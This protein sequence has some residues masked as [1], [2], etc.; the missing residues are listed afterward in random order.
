MDACRLRFVRPIAEGLGFLRE[1]GRRISVSHSAAEDPEMGLRDL[2]PNGGFGGLRL[3]PLSPDRASPE[4]A[5]AARSPRSRWNTSLQPVGGTEDA[6]PP[7]F[8]GCA[9]IRVVLRWR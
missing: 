8:H 9:S 7:R 3:G 1:S 6:R 4:R 5:K 2:R